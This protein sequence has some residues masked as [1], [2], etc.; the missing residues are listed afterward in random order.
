MKNGFAR[1]IAKSL[2]NKRIK[3]LLSSIE[4][5]RDLRL[6]CFSG[7]ICCFGDGLFF[8]LLPVYLNQLNASPTDVGMLYAVY[9]LSWVLTLMLGGFLA[10]HF[11]QKKIMILSLL[12]WIPMPLALATA[13]NWNQ[14]WIPMV[15]Y[16][17]YLGSSSTCAYIL[18]AAPSTRTMQSFGLWSASLALGYIFSPALGGFIASTIG[19]QTVFLMTAGFYAASVIPLAFI[20]K[21]PRADPKKSQKVSKFPPTEF[22]HYR[23]PAVLALFS[24]MI[25]FAV[26]LVSPLI[27]QFTH[28]FYHQS[29]LNLGVFGTATSFG[30][31]FFS[32]TLGRMGDKHSKMTAVLSSTVICSF[33]FLLIALINNFP[34]LCIAS[35]LSGTSSCLIGFAPALI[36]SAASE[37]HVG[38]WVS[39]GQTGIAVAS[40][41]APIIGGVLY[42]V[43]P[44]LAFFTAIA[45]LSA[46]T[47]VVTVKKL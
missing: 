43:S 31:F 32:L 41:G 15:L 28:D 12:L 7:F 17:A 25:A 34:L 4:I 11:D 29:I 19:K 38:Q 5:N 33:S 26:F 20:N 1:T 40:F 3:T 10:D 46:L 27:S 35:F 36:G 21:S 6:L 16:G 23:K 42:E 37:G 22:T 2:T 8:F 18:R 14:L 9:N 45:V 30:W 44:Y 39:I 13:T 47:A 24:S